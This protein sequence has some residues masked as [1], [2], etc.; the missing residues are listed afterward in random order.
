[1]VFDFSRGPGS[2][3]SHPFLM[4]R[5]ARS[6]LYRILGLRVLKFLMTQSRS[7]AAQSVSALSFH[8]AW[9]SVGGSGWGSELGHAE[10]K[11]S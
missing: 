3:S 7:G 4:R 5:L 10:G 9:M 8:P 2:V 6:L 1:V 11:V